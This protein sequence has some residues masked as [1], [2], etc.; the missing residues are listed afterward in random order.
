[1][2][3]IIRELLELNE[4]YCFEQ[5]HPELIY[6]VERALS[7][8]LRD[9]EAEHYVEFL[10]EQAEELARFPKHLLDVPTAEELYADGPPDVEIGALLD[11]PDVRVGLRVLDRP[12]SIIVAGAVGGGKTTLIR[13]IILG[14]DKLAKRRGK[15]IPIIAFVRKSAEQSDL[16]AL[17]GSNW[18]Y[19]HAQH[20]SWLGTNGPAG[21]PPN[22]WA[23]VVATLFAVA[24]GLIAAASVLAQVITWLVR[25]LNPAGQPALRWPSLPLIA[26][27]VR[28]GAR[29]F[30]EKLEYAQSLLQKLD[31][32]VRG[33]GTLLSTLRG[34]NFEDDVIARG[35]SAC[36][37]IGNLEPP[38]TRMFVVWLILAQILYARNQRAHRV[39]TTEVLVVLDEADQDVARSVETRFSGSLS[40][41]GALLQHG[42]EWGVLGVIGLHALG[43]ASREVLTNAPYHAIFN[44]SDE[45]SISEASRTLLL[46]RTAERILPAL[47]PGQCLFRQAQSC[48]PTPLLVGVD[49]VAPNRSPVPQPTIPD[50][51]PSLALCDMPELEEALRHQ[52]AQISN[53]RRR[54]KQAASSAISD[55]A[56][57]LLMLIVLHPAVPGVQLLKELGKRLSF[58]KQAAIRQE[59]E[60]AGYAEFDEERVGKFNLLLPEALEPGAQHVGKK[61]APIPGRGKRP[62]RTYAAWLMMLAER[63]SIRA[64]RELVVSGTTHP[65]D[66]AWEE[67]AGRWHAF[68]V[69]S[70]C[71]DNI[72]DHL[73]ACL[74]ES[75]MISRVTIVIPLLSMKTELL[76]AIDADRQLDGVRERIS[77][78]TVTQIYEELWPN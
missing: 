21:M 45:E 68:E 30:A 23:S 5:I 64:R 24:A 38:F 41:V 14:V 18:D 61:Y 53:S 27:T 22:V 52:E 76:A 60:K 58:G 63:K 46:P 29:A 11:Q 48:W 55:D 19:Y 71:S 36:I 43:Q 33:S 70:K 13:K 6:V 69:V 74:V 54:Q 44:L 34:V 16:P 26:E 49:Y 15:P 75:D 47:K 72:N 25:Q 35:R 62:H 40:P 7:G 28:H 20:G 51:M 1:M 4:H 56:L 32:A 8:K 3:P 2:S 31:D 57:S 67:A 10:R 59:L 73:R 9:A 77:F 37:D 66:V 42:R 12:R 78:Q 17:C 39:D 65:V 50:C